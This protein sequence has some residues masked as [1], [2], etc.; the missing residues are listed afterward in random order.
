MKRSTILSGPSLL[1]AVAVAGYS[2]P[3]LRP[4]TCI[5]TVD[6]T[7]FQKAVIREGKVDTA[8]PQSVDVVLRSGEVTATVDI[9]VVSSRH[10][11]G[12]TFEATQQTSVCQGAL[13]G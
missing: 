9:S 5:F 13:R 4:V 2:A 8:E 6:A 1:A 11:E 12:T 7:G 3:A 10:R